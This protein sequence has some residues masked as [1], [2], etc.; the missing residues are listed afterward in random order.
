MFVRLLKSLDFR[1][2]A[3]TTV[4]NVGMFQR[5]MKRR[6]LRAQ[7]WSDR[8]LANGKNWRADARKTDFI[9]ST[10][11]YGLV[12]VAFEDS[13]QNALAWGGIVGM[14]LM[15]AVGTVRKKSS[16]RFRI[17]VT[18]IDRPGDLRIVHRAKTRD[19]AM[20]RVEE[21]VEHL[22][23]GSSLAVLDALR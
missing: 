5:W 4:A 18:R 16:A 19:E 20:R 2:I 21:L 1:E 22:E 7:Q 6:D 10:S 23:D 8:R 15:I 9:V 14:L 11:K 12:R 3:G 17:G 13:A